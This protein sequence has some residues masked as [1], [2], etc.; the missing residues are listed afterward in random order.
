MKISPGR[1]QWRGRRHPCTGDNR[2]KGWS[3]RA[4]PHVQEMIVLSLASDTKVMEE[5]SVND[6][7][8]KEGTGNIML[9]RLE[10]TLQKLGYHCFKGP[11]LPVGKKKSI[12]G[13]GKDDIEE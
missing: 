10:F 6:V 12:N 8:W 11:C 7:V 3:Q 5:D 9:K 13:S 1:E 4:D 2:N